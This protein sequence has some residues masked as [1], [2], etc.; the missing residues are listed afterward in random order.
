MLW[1]GNANTLKNVVPQSLDYV[2]DATSGAA[3]VFIVDLF[4]ESKNV[5]A[6]TRQDLHID[7]AVFY[8]PTPDLLLFL[9]IQWMVVTIGRPYHLLKRIKTF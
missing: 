3:L 2:P 7:A 9:H 1:I 8:S 6:V 5:R 4:R